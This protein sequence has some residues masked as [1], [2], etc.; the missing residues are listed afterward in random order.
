MVIS[1]IR[2]L[3][4]QSIH[5]PRARPRLLAIPEGLVP[6]VAAGLRRPL[7]PVME[8]VVEPRVDGLTVLWLA[9]AE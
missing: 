6:P 7:L 2:S 4:V 8:V 9:D 5:A 3:S 1:R